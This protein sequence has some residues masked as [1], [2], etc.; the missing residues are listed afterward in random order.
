MTN[1]WD[2]FEIHGIYS[3]FMEFIW[4]LWHLFRIYGI[5]LGCMAFIASI[6]DICMGF[7]RC[8]LD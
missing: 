7:M 4:D 2:C 1:I 8:I 6:W 3:G 5:Y